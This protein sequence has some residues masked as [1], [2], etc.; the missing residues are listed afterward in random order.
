[1]TSHKT[2]K[3]LL[4]GAICV[5]LTAVCSWISIPAAVSFT[6][7]TF[8]IYFTLDVL[9]G[10]NGTLAVTAYVLLGAF[11]CPVFSGFKGGLAALFTPT[12]GY[13]VGFI[14]LA[15]TF[16]LATRLFGDSTPVKIVS[17]AIGTL[18]CYAFGTAWFMVCYDGMTLGAALMLCVVPFIP[19]DALKLAAAHFISKAVTRY[20]KIA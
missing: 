9:G 6:L 4:Y 13:I 5:A 15:L 20:A 19:I 16:W 3:T 11:G 14:F 7:Q 18:V 17:Q 10:R 2:L 1:M 12:G 8:A